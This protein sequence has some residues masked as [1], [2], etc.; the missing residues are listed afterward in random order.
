MRDILP[1]QIWNPVRTYASASAGRGK[2]VDALP[3]TLEEAE[4][5]C[6]EGG[7]EGSGR[8]ACQAGLATVA[9]VRAPHVGTMDIG[10]SYGGTQSIGASYV[11][12]QVNGTLHVGT[13][14]IGAPH[15]GTKDIGGPRIAARDIRRWSRRM[16]S[17][18]WV[19]D[20]ADRLENAV[21]DVIGQ[22]RG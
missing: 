1:R 19:R 7:R 13:H 12:T 3:L 22:L 4:F 16:P 14:V 21:R 11:G 5:L 8:S 18:D 2:V 15:V 17:C 9:A 20:C 6:F 10:T